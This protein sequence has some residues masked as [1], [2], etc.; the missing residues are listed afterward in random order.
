MALE[1]LV[2]SLG[3]Q[4]VYTVD[5]YNLKQVEETL[6]TCLADAAEAAPTV[7]IAQRECA[8]LPSARKTYVPLRVEASRC[9]ACGTCRRIGCP[10]LSKSDALYEKTPKP[11][12]TIDPLL[13]T[14]CE[15][16]AQVC[17]VGAILFRAQLETAKEGASR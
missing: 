4:R 15:I 17:P 8:L 3:I 2:R 12:T 10:A 16:C 13:C 5:P 1:P 6:K 7:I 14:G 11:K 9:I